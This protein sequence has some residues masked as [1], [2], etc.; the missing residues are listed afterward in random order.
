[1]ATLDSARDLLL[2]VLR[3]LYERSDR[4]D[5][6]FDLEIKDDAL[7]CTGYSMTTKRSLGFTIP[8]KSIEEGAYLAQF[9]PTVDKL[10]EL[11]VL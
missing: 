7:I 11:L 8:K 5:L 9:K 3:I 1:M 2:P 10:I 4:T 6:R